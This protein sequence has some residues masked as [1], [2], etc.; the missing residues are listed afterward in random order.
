MGVAIGILLVAATVASFVAINTRAA[1]MSARNADAAWTIDPQTGQ[2]MP[3]PGDQ[4]RHAHHGAGR[5]GG[6]HHGGGRHG[7]GHHGGGHR[8]GGHHGGGFFGGGGHTG[9][10][11]GGGHGFSGGD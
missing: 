1:R 2:P 7:G 8:G 4:G 11:H 6:G 10:G 3:P 9:G 5:H